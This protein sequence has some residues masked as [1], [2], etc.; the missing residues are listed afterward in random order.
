MFKVSLPSAPRARRSSC[1]WALA[2]AVG[3]AA[4]GLNAQAQPTLSLDQALRLAQERS[5]QLVAQD[6]AGAA[7]REMAAAAGQ[8][9]DPTLK[10]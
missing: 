5:R 6:A 1:R 3:A 10:A 4:V 9:P 8:L 2:L 7:A